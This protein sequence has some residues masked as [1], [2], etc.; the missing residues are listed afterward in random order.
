MTPLIE[1]P[2]NPNSVYYAGGD[3]SNNGGSHMIKLD[4]LS[5][6]NTITA[7][8]MPFDFAA[9]SGG[10]ISAMSYSP[11]D[12]SHWYVATNN[13]KFFHS[14]D[15]GSTWTMSSAFT[16]PTSH[17]FYGSSIHPSQRNPGTVFLAGSG[18]SNF[19]VFRSDDHGQTF[20]NISNGLP[21]TLVYDIVGTNDD[22]LLFAATEVGPYV[23]VMRDNQ[24]YD[25]A[26]NSAPDQT[27]WSVEY[28]Q[29]INTIR[30]GT[31]GRGIW[32][33]KIDNLYVGQEDIAFDDLSIELFPN[34][35]S[36]EISI[37][38]STISHPSVLKLYDIKGTL[39]FERK[40]AVLQNEQIDISKLRQGLYIIDISN[41]SG[42]TTHKFVKN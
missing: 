10:F 8:Q 26:K 30:F 36:H 20:T 25:L 12:I 9:P 7:N 4:Y 13:G 15:S 18:Y 5:L 41:R 22:S 39:L 27:Y 40:F 17:Y 35:A 24:W 3:L 42:R 38:S 2:L 14:S 23:Y 37:R 31:Y 1:N 32:D 6:N 16:G 19:P 21:S 33:F 29:L 28:V 11:L 34:P